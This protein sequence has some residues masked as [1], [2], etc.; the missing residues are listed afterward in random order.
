[1]WQER[2]NEVV[3]VNKEAIMGPVLFDMVGRVDED[4]LQMGRMGNYK[5][6]MNNMLAATWSFQLEEPTDTVF[7]ADYRHGVSVLNRLQSLGPYSGR[8]KGIIIGD[9]SAA[10]ICFSA[11]L[12]VKKVGDICWN[13]C[14]ILTIDPVGISDYR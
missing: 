1:M 5:Y 6:D 2:H 14:D 8:N 4:K 9:E 11:P 13:D 7:D 3:W 12:F 10:K